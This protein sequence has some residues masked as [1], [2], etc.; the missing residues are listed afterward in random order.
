MREASLAIGHG[1]FGTTMTALVAGVPQLV[2][3]LFAGDQYINAERIHAVQAGLQLVDGA[4]SIGQVPAAVKELLDDN[5]YAEAA[6]AIAA[7]IASLPDVSSVVPI[8]HDLRS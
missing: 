5:R 3:P 8:L 6:R 2:M 4:E 7:E 1:G